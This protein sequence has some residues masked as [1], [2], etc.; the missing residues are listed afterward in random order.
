MFSGKNIYSTF[1]SD[2]VPEDQDRTGTGK[3][4][5]SLSSTDYAE[6][7]TLILDESGEV[8]IA[9]SSL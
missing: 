9:T 3:E 4:N 2:L 7:N 5:E 1:C 6:L 8:A